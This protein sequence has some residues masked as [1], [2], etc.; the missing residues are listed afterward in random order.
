MRIFTLSSILVAFIVSSISAYLFSLN[1]INFENLIWIV[2]GS[3]AIL[4][5]IIYQDIYSELDSQKIEQKRLDEKL[6]IYGRLS[7]IEER[8]KI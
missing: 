4:L 3:M 1:R 5:M 8:L 6:K 2:I 7:K